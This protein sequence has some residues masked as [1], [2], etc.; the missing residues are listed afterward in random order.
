[1]EDQIMG[2]H[3]IEKWPN[4]P[5][6]LA[7]ELRKEFAEHAGDARV[8]EQLISETERVRV[9]SIRLKPGERLG[10]HTHVLDYFW[11]A[12][13]GGRA[14]SHFNDGRVV[15]VV[16]KPGDV[17]HLAFKEGELMIHDLENV[18]ETDLL[19]TTVEFLD[20]PNAPLPLHSHER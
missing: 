8:G 16:Y 17:K 11:T 10:F 5:A 4:A 13:T 14:R 20:S 15:D 19:F 9:W 18:G 6:A 7:P 12:V 3:R 1:M 2:T